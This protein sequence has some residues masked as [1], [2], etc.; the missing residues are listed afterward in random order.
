MGERGLWSLD[1]KPK[2]AERFLK[3]TWTDKE[4]LDS[5]KGKKLRAVVEE[6]H[7]SKVLLYSEEIGWLGTLNFSE[8][9]VVVLSEKQE[10]NHPFI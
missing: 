3:R 7:P 6:I 5:F 10:G 8:V 9:Q 2:G 4:L 1:N